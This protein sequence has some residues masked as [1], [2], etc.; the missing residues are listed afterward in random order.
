MTGARKPVSS[1]VSRINRLY[2]VLQLL[3]CAAFSGDRAAKVLKEIQKVIENQKKEGTT[4][5]RPL[6]RES[7]HVL[8]ER[9][10]GESLSPWATS[11]LYSTTKIRYY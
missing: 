8:V 3:A 4:A 6:F 1:K 7:L 2:Y 10:R 11:Q 5:G 9:E